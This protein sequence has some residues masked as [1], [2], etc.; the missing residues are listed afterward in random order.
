MGTQAKNKLACKQD[1]QDAL[2]AGQPHSQVLSPTHGE[3]LVGSGHIS[4]RIWEIKCEICL[5]RA[6]MENCVPDL[7]LKVMTIKTKPRMPKIMHKIL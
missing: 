3:T 5:C 1:L 4:P 6:Y 2:A 7:V